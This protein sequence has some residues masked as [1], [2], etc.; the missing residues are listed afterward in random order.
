[1]IWPVVDGVETR[2]RYAADHDPYV[3]KSDGVHFYKATAN[4]EKAAFWLRPWHPPAETPDDEYPFWL[5]TGRVLEH[6]HTGSMTRRVKQLHQAVPEGY[7]EMNRSDAADLS[8]KAGDRV[9]VVS[10]RGELELPV[11]IEGRGQPPRGTV[12][13]PF[14]D[15]AKLPNVLTL[16]A[17]DNIS[18]EPD[19]KKCAVR[20]ELV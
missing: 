7:V 14:F 1:M 18:K 12:F 3:Q 8:L 2:W 11:V 13:I 20:L 9:R 5:C 15:E 6:W 4:G 10:R 17:M 19:F 16:D